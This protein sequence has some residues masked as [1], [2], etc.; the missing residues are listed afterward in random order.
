MTH[1]QSVR[2][3]PAGQP[4]A[5]APP[6][7]SLKFDIDN[8]FQLELRRRVDEYFRIH[9]RRQRDCWQMYLKTAVLLAG[10]AGSYLLLVFVAQTWWQ[11]LLLVTLLGLSAAGIGF[12]VQHDGSHQAYSNYPWVNA[13]MAR[14][15]ELI[16]GSSYLWRWKHVVF[17][18]TYVN[19]TGHDTDIDLGV[20]ARLTPH[21][22][23]RSFHRWQHLYLW[24]LYGLLVI[25]WQLLDDFRK[26]V[27]G[28]ISNQR[29]PRPRGWELVILAGGKAIFLALAFGIPLVFHPV[30][31]VLLYYGIAGLV[32]GTVLSVVF[33]VAH[34]V[35]EAEFPVARASTGRI[36]HAWAVHQ[37]ET[38]VDFA[39]RSRVVTWLVGGLNYQTEHHLF[40]RICHVNY[41]AISTLVEETCRD[42]GIR[43]REFPSFRAGI[44]SHFRWLRQM[45][46]GGVRIPASV[47]TGSGP[48]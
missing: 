23:R 7:R 21:Q 10:F 40:P 3:S 24:P 14:T 26:L 30:S 38:T 43:Y 18:H 42:F 39:R 2:A 16:G 28:R 12:N 13:L 27:R 44:A 31:V 6:S 33:Q 25:K 48:S 8:A 46:R 34:C 36:G 35:D 32:A 4:I 22:K 19:I 47:N 29:F 5:T 17:H 9:G 41:P 1:H 20:L 45:G 11:G 37:T 15:L